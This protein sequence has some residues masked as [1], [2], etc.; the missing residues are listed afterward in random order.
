MPVIVDRY[1]YKQCWQYSGSNTKADS[2]KQFIII[3]F[4]YERISFLDFFRIDELVDE[5]ATEDQA[6]EAFKKHI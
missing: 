4:L 1:E 6:L 3:F 5:D 2:T